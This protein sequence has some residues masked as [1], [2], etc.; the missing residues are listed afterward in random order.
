MKQ[1][2]KLGTP[3]LKDFGDDNFMLSKKININ[4]NN[5]SKE[6]IRKRKKKRKKYS[7]FQK[8]QNFPNDLKFR[9]LNITKIQEYIFYKIMSK[10]LIY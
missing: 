3:T 10:I 4:E 1:A 6:S 7:F 2:K 5:C 9:N 8:K